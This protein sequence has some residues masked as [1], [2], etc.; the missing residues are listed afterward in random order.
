MFKESYEE[1]GLAA[2]NL[3]RALEDSGTM[4]S[5]LV[6]WNTCGAFIKLVKNIRDF[7]REMKLTR[8]VS[9]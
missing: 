4:S 1:R 6:P 5:P 2:K 8:I 3:S 9:V 7:S